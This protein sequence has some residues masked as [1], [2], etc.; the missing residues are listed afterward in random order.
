VSPGEP[1]API[2]ARVAELF[3]REQFVVESLTVTGTD[4][5]FP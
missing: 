1:P 2:D 3:C 4:P 5:D